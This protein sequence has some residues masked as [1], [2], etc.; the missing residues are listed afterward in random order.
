MY[1]KINR[2]VTIILSEDSSKKYKYFKDKD[3]LSWKTP[4]HYAAELNYTT[5]AQSILCHYPGQLYIT[6]N[7]HS[8]NQ[9]RRSLPVE[10][11]LMRHNDDVSA[12]LIE[13]MKPERY[14]Y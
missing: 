8:A 7:P 11:S 5:V 4:L 14:M 1:F 6:T 2:L 13:N 12:F 3:E 9:N 10:L